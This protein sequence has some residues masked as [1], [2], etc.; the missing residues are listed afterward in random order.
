MDC[1]GHGHVLTR[2]RWIWS[3]LTSVAAMVGGGVEPRGSTAAEQIAETI[4]AA[5]AVLRDSIS[6]DVH[7]HGG[8][9]GITSTAPPSD[10][11]AKAMRTGSLAVACLA[12]VPDTPIHPYQE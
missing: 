1:C 8:A 7:T 10:D 12:D 3:T 6:V 4:A 11:L 9:S 5:L 2:R